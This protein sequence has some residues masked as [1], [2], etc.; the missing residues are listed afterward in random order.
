MSHIFFK[1]QTLN[2]E[3]EVGIDNILKY[4]PYL[5]F[6]YRYMSSKSF[7]ACEVLRLIDTLKKLTVES[8][9]FLLKCNESVAASVSKSLKRDYDNVYNWVVT[10][11]INR[12]YLG[13]FTAVFIWVF[14]SKSIGTVSSFVVVANIIFGK[15]YGR[16]KNLKILDYLIFSHIY[17]FFKSKSLYKYL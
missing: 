13:V 16:M 2:S 3:G 4:P 17:T 1:Y 12:A 5:I 11:Y 7:S 14:H 6:N 8:G 9:I 15:I 10:K